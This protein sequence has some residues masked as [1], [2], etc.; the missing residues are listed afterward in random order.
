MKS[1]M[2]LSLL[3]LAVALLAVGCSNNDNPLSSV[4]GN[5]AGDIRSDRLASASATGDVM[6]ATLYLYLG[7]ASGSDVYLHRVTADWD[8]MTVTWNNFG[9]AFD[10]AVAT[11]FASDAV[12]WKAVDVTVLVQDWA[13]GT[14]DNF[15]ILMEA[16]DLNFPRTLVNS[17]N[18]PMNQPYLEVCYEGMG[19]ELVAAMADAY[20]YELYPDANTGA[21]ELLNIGW[22]D[23]VDLEKQSLIR[24]ELPEVPPQDE[25]CTRTIG[26]WKTHAGFGPQ[27][28]M[29]TQYLPITLGTEGGAG[30]LLVSDAAT[31]V[32]V[33]KMKTYGSNSNG[34]TKLYAQLLGAKLNIAAGTG[35]SMVSEVIADADAFL[36]DHD[37]ADWSNLSAADK[38]MVLGWQSDLDDYNNGL[39]GPIHC[40]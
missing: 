16:G 11:M 39:M 35:Y 26:Y 10:P 1:V 15:G 25:G 28:D 34:I 19:C 6:S 32:N 29:V 12:G 17:R 40:E 21:G 7:Q 14:Y 22:Y 13:G 9:G 30:S 23:E 27:A 2:H 38:N 37:W 24:F 20:I 33:L 31:A 8:E 36:A 18:N 4:P 3:V 5:T